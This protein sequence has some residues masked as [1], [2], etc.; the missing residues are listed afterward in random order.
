MIDLSKEISNKVENRRIQKAYANTF[1]MALMLLLAFLP[2]IVIIMIPVSFMP[3]KYV[4]FIDSASG[5]IV[6]MFLVYAFTFLFCRIL[7]KIKFREIFTRPHINQ[8]EAILYMGMFLLLLGFDEIVS[9]L[10][11]FIDR[12]YGTAF[13]PE[14]MI[15]SESTAT[16]IFVIYVTACIMAPLFE[17]IL[18][19]GYMLKNLL[20]DTPSALFSIILSGTVFSLL[21]SEDIR[22][23]AIIPSGIIWGYMA[24][25]TG[26]VWVTVFFHAINNT[27]AIFYEWLYA[28]LA[29]NYSV[30]IT[31]NIMTTFALIRLILFLAIG[32]ILVRKSKGDF[33]PLAK[34]DRKKTWGLVYRNV[35]F[36]LFLG[37]AAY[38]FL[39]NSFS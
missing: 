6:M 36:Y 34:M 19:R 27:L 4:D 21:H 1:W 30:A 9:F 16:E 39:S 14:R 28:R 26:S 2:A 23:L 29:V 17:E 7:T 11:E 25:K 37:Y 35:P 32:L 18:C 31:D 38:M 33:V 20:R 3:E 15:T 12:L 10:F 8:R 13:I 5:E 24:Y 22:V